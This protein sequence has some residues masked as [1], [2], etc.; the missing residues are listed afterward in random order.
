MF[1]PAGL[2][3]SALSLHNSSEGI[4]ELLD[5]EEFRSM[6][7]IPIPEDNKVFN[8]TN[9]LTCIVLSGVSAGKMCNMSVDSIYLTFDDE[10]VK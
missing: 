8:L 7:N 2:I 6:F 5:M 9:L 1:V 4:F 10:I 3:Q